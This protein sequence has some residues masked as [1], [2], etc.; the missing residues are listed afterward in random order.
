MRILSGVQSSG[1]LHLGNYYGALR[2]FVAMQNE[3]EALYFIANLHA[4]NSVRDPVQAKKLTFDT[5]VAFLALGLDPSRA[6]LFRQSDIP[7]VPE[8]YWILGTVVPVSNLERAH[9]YKD[10]IDKGQSPDFGLFA[11][12]VLMAV[13]IMLYDSDVVPV[14]KDQVQHLE[15]A[16]DWATKFNV[17]YVPKYDPADPEG[18]K[19]PKGL[20]KP[21]RALVQEE[22]A[23]I[24]GVDGQKMSKTYGN[25]IELFA[26]IKATEK[27]MMGIKTD[28]TAVESPKP[29][30]GSALYQLL[31]VMAPASEWAALD[32]SWRQGGQG[33]GY[34]KKKL[35]ECFHVTFDGPRKRYEEL[36]ADPAEVERILKA[37]AAKAREYAAPVLAR[38]RT[39]VG[40]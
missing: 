25:T 10:K 7:E 23:L 26:E 22:T 40:L 34:Y 29:V 39:A 28:S 13:D 31:K 19:G 11:Y 4:L 8:L 36:Q 12:P 14:G 30:E 9:S 38:V 6:V 24:P 17:T 27:K 33:Y 35:V 15:F 1:Q 16:R 32:A 18:K 21:P 2:Q 20:L 3:G 5:A 37:G